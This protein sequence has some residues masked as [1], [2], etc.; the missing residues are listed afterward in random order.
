M[1]IWDALKVFTFLFIWKRIFVDTVS[2]N[3]N[4]SVDTVSTNKKYA[5]DT[6]STNKKYAVDTVSPN[7]NYAV[8]TVSTNKSYTVG[9][10][11]NLNKKCTLH[12]RWFVQKVTFALK[13]KFVVKLHFTYIA[14]CTCTLGKIYN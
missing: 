4:Y 10:Q 14:L 2:T 5:V 9:T 13:G 11:W 12:F 1:I 8:D 7:K 6:V 3:K